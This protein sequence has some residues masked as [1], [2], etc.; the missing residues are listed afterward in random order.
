MEDKGKTRAILDTLNLRD[1]DYSGRY[2]KL[3]VVEDSIIDLQN[4]VSQWL[5]QTLEEY[6]FIVNLTG[7]NKLMSLAAYDFFKELGSD[8]VYVPIPQNRCL[9]PFPK[10]RPKSPGLLQDR[11]TVIEYLTAC[12]FK[13]NNLNTLERNR[14]RAFSR[15]ELT[16]F[17][18]DQYE[19]VKP[20]LKW[21]DKTSGKIQ[22]RV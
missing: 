13:I 14:Q 1:L 8:M 21:L 2:Q 7:G 16:N 10:L 6:Q 9:V 20:L 22:K 17:I 5:S 12:N 18:F 15:K 19:Q 11:L 3:E 4:K